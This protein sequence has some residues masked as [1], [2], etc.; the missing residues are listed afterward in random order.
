MREKLSLYLDKSITVI[1]LAVAGLTPLIFFNQTTE[2]FEIPKLLFLIV[3]TVLVTGLWIFSWIVKGKISFSRTPLDIALIFFLIIVI[4]S[5]FLSPTRLVA[6]YGNFPRVHG[7]AV[8][9]AIYILLYFVIVSQLRS[10]KSIKNLIYVMLGSGVILSVIALLSYFRIFLP[11]DFAKAVNFTPTGS[12][13]STAAFLLMLL[14]IPVL[15]LI[16]KNKYMPLPVAIAITLLFSIVVVLIGSVPMAALIAGIFVAGILIS[17]PAQVKKNILYVL[18]PAA[19][20]VLVAVLTYFPLVGPLGFLNNTANNFPKEIQLP[21]SSSWKVSASALRDAPFLGTGPSSFAFNF[22]AYKPAEFNTYPFWN[23]TFDTAYNELFQ[24]IATLGVLGLVGLL[25]IAIIVLRSVRRNL[26]V[27]RRE[28]ADDDS[29]ILLPAL[30]LAALVSVVL[31]LLHA[32]TIVSIVTTLFILGAFMMAQKPIREKVT[33]LSMGLRATT[34]DNRKI[35]L[36]PVIIFIVFLVVALPFMLNV[37]RAAQA[38][39][40]HRQALNQSFENGTLT[41]EYLQKAEQLN[42]NIALYRVDLAQTNFALANAIAAQKGPTEENPEGT[43]T[44]EDRQTIQTLLS[45]A[46]NEG[47]AAVALSPRSA[48]N[49]EVLGSLYRNITGVAQNALEFSLAAYGQAIQRDPLNPALRASVGGIYFAAGNYELAAR[50]FTDAANLKPDY[51]NAYYNLAVT[52]RETGDITNAVLVA[53]Q[54]VNILA[55]N[56]DSQDYKTAVALLEELN[57]RLASQEAEA[58]AAQAATVVDEETAL[59][60]PDLPDITTLNNPPE[61]SPAPAV[62]PNPNTNLP[63][64]TVNLSPTPAA[65]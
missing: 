18:I 27:H 62:Q 6:I 1:L 29:F 19:T 33:E 31:L 43:L 11:F 25:I 63:R 8:S 28:G 12:S 42:P 17:K 48:S 32:T 3:T 50:F 36:F 55:D 30:T 10:L 41:Y 51:A 14:P 52:F 53:Q 5:A 44:D 24:V 37:V 15:S 56:P 45:Q 59:Q 60:N 7:A 64:P 4:A 9:W 65:N 20:V 16:N 47:R 34:G 46:I 58:Q 2:F 23:F 61:V 38:D 57:T 54:L 39:Y 22:S 26:S 13:F 40:Y 35:D 21:L 49:W